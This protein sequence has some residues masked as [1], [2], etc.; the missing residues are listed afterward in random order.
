MN[1]TDKIKSY[2]LRKVYDYLD[3]DPDNNIPKLMNWV[4]KFD[5]N[6]NFEVQRNVVRQVIENPD[7]N[8]YRLIKSLWTDIDSGV[9]RTIF[10]NFILNASLIGWPK[11]EEYRKKYN[12][13]IPWTI[14]M[15]PTSACN[16]K[17]K[18][19]WAAE[20][21][22]KLNMDY[23]TLDSIICQGK[24]LGIYFFIYSGG[25]PLVRKKDIISLCEKHSDCVFL[26]FTN[27]TL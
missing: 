2:G 8:W 1:V 4:D 22:S 14:L 13:N 23:E 19:C 5:R 21:G 12:C 25:E 9:R 26:S 15:D 17:C 6:N 24:E 18:G 3:K 16:L 10:E 27:A 20:Y 11:Q 7:S